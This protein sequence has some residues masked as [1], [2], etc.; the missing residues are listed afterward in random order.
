M[1]VDRG[2][3]LYG[4]VYLKNIVSVEW[5]NKLIMYPLIVQILIEDGIALK[6]FHCG[7][8]A[9]HL[10][11]NM[12]GESLFQKRLDYQSFPILCVLITVH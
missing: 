1:M 7:D 11:W 10:L 3:V 12:F 8:I 6:C 5:W 9:A 2:F 4:P